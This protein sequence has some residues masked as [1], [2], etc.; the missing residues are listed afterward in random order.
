[1]K[2]IRERTSARYSDD[3]F[4]GGRVSDCLLLKKAARYR[5]HAAT[6]L[7]NAE[8][9]RE[10]ATRRAHLAVARHFYLLAE[11]EIGQREAKRKVLPADQH[12]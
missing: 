1:V 8:A 12:P 11:E 7:A 9:A 3:C 6:S 4:M 10:D 5:T 2:S